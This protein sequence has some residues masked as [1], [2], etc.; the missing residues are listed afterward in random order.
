[1]ESTES[2]ASL[3]RNLKEWDEAKTHISGVLSHCKELRGAL[4]PPLTKETVRADGEFT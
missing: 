3:K 1:M 2:F 4:F